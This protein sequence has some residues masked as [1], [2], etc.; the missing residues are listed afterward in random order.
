[1]VTSPTSPYYSPHTRIILIT[2]PPVNPNQRPEDPTR[3]NVNTEAYARRVVDVAKE[4]EVEVVDVW[5][6]LWEK[7]D[8]KEERLAPYL[9]DGLHL[10][11]AGYEVSPDA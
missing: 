6:L 7:A 2:P 8:S 5:G 9:S 10:T 3:N 1:M 11:A 4:T